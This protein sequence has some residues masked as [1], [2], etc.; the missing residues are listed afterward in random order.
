MHNEAFIFQDIDR[1]GEP[2]DCVQ[3]KDGGSIALNVQGEGE[4]AILDFHGNPGSRLNNVIGSQALTELGVR[5]IGFDRPGYGRST[6]HRRLLNTTIASTQETVRQ[7]ADSLDLK[8]FGIIARSGGVPHALACA[9]DPSLNLRITGV[10]AMS[11]LAPHEFDFDW[12][13]SMTSDNQQKHKSTRANREALEENI[14]QHADE[15][16]EDKFALLRHLWPDLPARDRTLLDG[17]Y[18]DAVATNHAEGL[19]Q[20]GKGWVDDTLLLNKPEGWGFAL[21]NIVLPVVIWQGGNDPFVWEY[22]ARSLMKYIPNAVAVHVP[23]AGHFGG[24]EYLETAYGYL[25]DIEATRIAQGR[26]DAQHADPRTLVRCFI[27][28]A[29]DTSSVGP[30]LLTKSGHSNELHR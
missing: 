25:R 9:A 4:Y 5:V 23:R 8:R 17:S 15:V 22:H 6:P 1:E 2:I 16:R 11:G 18:G 26:V 28:S 12:T 30:Y 7:I 29:A 3:L 24:M 10:V 13:R 19:R 20:F 14:K 21:R 27:G